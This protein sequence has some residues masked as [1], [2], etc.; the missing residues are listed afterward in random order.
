MSKVSPECLIVLTRSRWL[1][2]KFSSARS[3]MI[4]QVRLCCKYF[5]EPPRK[6]VLTTSLLC[7]YGYRTKKGHNSCRLCH[8]VT[9]FELAMCS[10]NLSQCH[11]DNN[12]ECWLTILILIRSLFAISL[13]VENRKNVRFEV[14][15]ANLDKTISRLS[16]NF[17]TKA[18]AYKESS[19][20]VVTLTDLANCNHAIQGC[21]DFMTHSC[22]KLTF[23]LSSCRC[24]QAIKC[25]QIFGSH[26][27][28]QIALMKTLS[29]A[30]ATCTHY[31]RSTPLICGI[32]LST[33]DFN[34]FNLPKNC[35]RDIILWCDNCHQVL[36]MWVN[37]PKTLNARLS[38]QSQWFL[39]ILLPFTRMRFPTS[40]LTNWKWSL[41]KQVVLPLHAD[42][43]VCITVH[44]QWSIVIGCPPN[45]FQFIF[46]KGIYRVYQSPWPV[47]YNSGIGIS[48]VLNRRRTWTAWCLAASSA[49]LCSTNSVISDCTPT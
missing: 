35:H 14:T 11:E 46:H 27:I 24:L 9:V 43:V 38:I 44:L 34:T 47:P 7:R 12:A 28:R 22:Q 36:C 20:C 2:V 15:L 25:V 29:S 3:C 31:A 39:E 30:I 1:G 32:R 19:A 17:N 23:C 45:F 40:M 41:T 37:T 26:S 21:S 48:F 16:G 5:S 42:V 4:E 10:Q 49:F 13:N 18:C 33:Q 8:R 6:N